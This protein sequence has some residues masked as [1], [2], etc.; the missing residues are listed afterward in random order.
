M[1]TLQKPQ[2]LRHVEAPGKMP[3]WQGGGREESG[4][5]RFTEKMQL[6]PHNSPGSRAIP[7]PSSY[8]VASTPPPSK[9]K[10]L[11]FNTHVFP[12]PGPP[13]PQPPHHAIPRPPHQAPPT[14][15]LKPRRP[16][17]KRP[18]RS[19]SNTTLPHPPAR[20]SPTIHP[21]PPEPQNLRTALGRRTRVQK[22][23]RDPPRL[24][25][26][27]QHPRFLQPDTTPPCCPRR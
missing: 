19:L 6:H 25:D 21:T 14:D 3:P 18:P 11:I 15:R 12:P 13:P 17:P 5:W 7:A 10:Y 2:H 20:N 9:R 26:G 4:A 24:W 8:R 27:H 23:R 22:A 1:L 16:K